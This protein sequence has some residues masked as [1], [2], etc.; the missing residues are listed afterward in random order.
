MRRVC[1]LILSLLAGGAVVA[2]QPTEEQL[3]R[4]LQRFPEA[5]RNKDGR[6]TVEEASAYRTRLQPAN[7]PGRPAGR[8]GVQRDFKVDP[9]WEAERFPAHAVCYLAPEQIRA[10]Y[11]RGLKSGEQAVTSFPKPEDG[12]LRIVGTGHS[13]MAPGYHALPHICR[14]AGFEQPLHLH[15][16]G[17]MTG[18]ARYKWEEENGIFQFDGKPKPKLLASIANAE[19]EAMMWG[20]YFKDR[21]AFYRCWIEFCLQYNPDM[22]FYL[23]DAW[24]QVEDLG[25]V[26]E[27][28][29][30]LTA[31]TIARLGRE[32]HGKYAQ[33][34]TE[35]NREF[36]GK[37][38]I[39]PTCDA[40]V[41]A[42]QLFH[43]GE[44][45]G[46]EGINRAIGKKERSLWRDVL[47]HLGPGFDRLE[48]YV[49]YASLY[50]RSPELIDRE[51]QFETKDGFPS[52]ELDRVFRKI[53]WEAVTGNGLS[54][55]TDRD[56][57]GLGDELSE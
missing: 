13:F 42:A 17:G 29:E 34:V 4:L 21:P 12:A 49:F 51:I 44:L 24:P 35:L 28:E 31:E 48:G 52:R 57:D 6:L 45:P 26:P 5:D 15:T 2:Q 36:P 14:A 3:A 37:V 30:V 39:L 16:G 40:M 55:V 20:P 50:K 23:S 53:A 27:S 11:A 41:R 32:K 10:T 25:A 33:L 9:G 46:V 43:R 19:W 7:R 1:F 18:S 22:R 56:G 8:R 47:G 54:G 38:F